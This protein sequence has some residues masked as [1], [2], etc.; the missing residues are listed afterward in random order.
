MSL[1]RFL[2]LKLTLLSCFQVFAAADRN[3]QSCGIEPGKPLSNAYGPWDF[4]NPAHQDRLPIVLGAHFTTSVENHIAGS[5]N[6]IIGDLDYTLRAIPNYHRALASM[7]KYQRQ[8]KMNFKVMD[9]YYTADC[10]FK[11]AI[12]MQPRDAVS[13]MLYASHLQLTSR[14]DEAEKYYIQALELQPDNPEIHYNLGL[15]YVKSGQL[16]RASEHADFAYK[17]HYPLQGLRNL[18]EQKAGNNSGVKED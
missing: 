4:T 13:L 11:R 16:D 10:Y 6:T 15:L 8:K 1:F 5:R 9:I 3:N 14:L 2:I 18:L 7:A 17:N 12:Y